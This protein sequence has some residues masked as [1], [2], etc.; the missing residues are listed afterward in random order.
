MSAA[1]LWVTPGHDAELCLDCGHC[2]RDHADK[3]G[4]CFEGRCRVK[5]QKFRG[6]PG[7][8]PNLL[9]KFGYDAERFA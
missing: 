1:T 7:A 8:Q 9:G 2:C 6:R 4:I 5:C 3:V